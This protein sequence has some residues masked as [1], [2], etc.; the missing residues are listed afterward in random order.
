[1]SHKIFTYDQDDEMNRRLAQNIAW[2][3]LDKRGALLDTLMCF[4]SG[5]VTGFGIVF[6]VM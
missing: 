1:M 2:R 3:K 4:C 5:F 6:L